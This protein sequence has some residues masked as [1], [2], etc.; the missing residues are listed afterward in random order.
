MYNK[1]KITNIKL[2]SYNIKNIINNKI[3]ILFIFF[4][5]NNN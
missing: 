2:K 1:T 5:Y 4:Y 3:I